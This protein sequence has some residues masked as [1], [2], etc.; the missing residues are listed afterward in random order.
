MTHHDLRCAKSRPGPDTHTHGH[1]S[2][3]T[4]TFYTPT[5]VHTDTHTRVHTYNNMHACIHRSTRLSTYIM[6]AHTYTRRLTLMQALL[7][8]VPMRISSTRP[9]L[10]RRFACSVPTVGLRVCCSCCG[11]SSSS[12]P[13]SKKMM[14][15]SACVII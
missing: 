4:Y 5:D 10:S 14:D 3:Q 8:K 2:I 12:L 6:H 11:V 7:F 15:E 9:Y 1:T 13:S